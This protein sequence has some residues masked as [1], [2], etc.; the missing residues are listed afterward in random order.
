MKSM[1]EVNLEIDTLVLDQLTISNL[2]DVKDSLVN[3]L[4]LRAEG[5]GDALFDESPILDIVAIS[6]Y[7]SAID[8]IVEYLELP[9]EEEDDL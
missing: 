9:A 5:E 2:R 1:T 4:E 8:K 3:L 7:I 6:E